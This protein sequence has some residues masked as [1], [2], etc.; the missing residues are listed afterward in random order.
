MNSSVSLSVLFALGLTRLLCI[1][2]A[3]ERSAICYIQQYY[4]KNR[5]RDDDDDWGDCEL[6][7]SS[8]FFRTP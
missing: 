2:S 5:R 8:F 1:R 7:I 3:Q 6:V 4:D